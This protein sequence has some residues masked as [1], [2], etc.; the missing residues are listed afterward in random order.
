MRRVALT[1]A[2]SLALAVAGPAEAGKFNKKVSIGDP[3]PSF[4]DLPGVNGK[5]HSLADY[6]DKD[7]VV[8]VV[9]CNHCPVAVAYEDRIIELTKKYA[10]DPSS[11]VA[12]VAINVNNIPADKLDKMKERAKSKGFNFPYLYDES[13]K[14]GRSLGA[15]VTPEIFVLNKERKI[16]YMGALDD[17]QNAARVSHKYVED[18]IDATLKGEAVKTSETRGRGCSIKYERAR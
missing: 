16:V 5:N 10:S 3:A 11:K 2:V 15:T 4:S 1:V 7:V 13:Q 18:A 8:L 14:I 9:T 6:K 12:V 17:S